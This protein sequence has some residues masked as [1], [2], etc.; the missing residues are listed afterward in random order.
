L[1]EQ[2]PGGFDIHFLVIAIGPAGFDL[3]IAG[4][5]AAH[6]ESACIK[7]LDTNLVDLGHQ[8]LFGFV[9]EIDFGQRD[10]D[11]HE[12]GTKAGRFVADRTFLVIVEPGGVSA[13][14]RGQQRDQDEFFLYLVSVDLG[15]S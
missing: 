1:P 7:I 14:G 2:R 6:G 4:Q 3:G 8:F 10:G 12:V 11:P 5:A 13:D 9:T 15:F